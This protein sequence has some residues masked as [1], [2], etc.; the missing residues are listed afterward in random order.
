MFILLLRFSFLKLGSS[1]LIKASAASSKL[2]NYGVGG[3]TELLSNW[4]DMLDRKEL[5]ILCI[6]LDNSGLSSVPKMMNS[7]F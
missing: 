3:S 1:L 7:P 4:K 6:L 5:P 2:F